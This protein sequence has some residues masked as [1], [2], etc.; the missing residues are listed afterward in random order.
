M[1]NDQEQSLIDDARIN[2]YISNG[3]QDQQ[4]TCILAHQT[5]DVDLALDLAGNHGSSN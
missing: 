2:V 1:V 4:T 5:V 3:S